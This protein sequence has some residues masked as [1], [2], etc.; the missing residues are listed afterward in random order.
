MAIKTYSARLVKII[1]ETELC[2]TYFFDL[3]EEI[4]FLPGQFVMVEFAHKLPNVRRAYSIAS[5]SSEKKIISLTV[6]KEGVF[7]SALDKA[8]VGEEFL[9]KGP[10]GQFI[11]DGK[12]AQDLVFIAGGTGVTP[13]R[14]MIRFILEKHL[15]NK[16]ALIYSCRQPGDFLYYNELISLAKNN[17]QFSIV[18]TATR[19]TDPGWKG[20][21]KRIDIQLITDYVPDYKKRFYYL[22]GPKEMV[23]AMSHLLAGMGVDKPNIKTERWG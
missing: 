12:T 9:I 7:T 22:C 8:A 15:P 20:L 16:M 11:L 1:Q 23:D 3:D 6:K 21:C 4:E 19:C 17:P 13:F 2:K 10:Y 14:S 5:P 18:F